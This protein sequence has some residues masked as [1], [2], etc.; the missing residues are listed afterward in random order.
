MHSLLGGVV[1]VMAGRFNRLRHMAA[2]SHPL[3]PRS[4]IPKGICGWRPE[5]DL[6]G[7]AKGLELLSVGRADGLSKKKKSL[8][9]LG[10]KA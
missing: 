9:T 1:Q 10:S 4:R 6:Y 8:N 7:S 2:V 3:V 5:W